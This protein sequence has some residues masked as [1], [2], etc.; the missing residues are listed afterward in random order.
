MG[1]AMLIICAG[2]LISMGFV[3]ISTSN[4]GKMLTQQ[5]VSYAEYTMA[6]NAAHTAIQIAMQ[7]INKDT[8][9]AKKHDYAK[10]WKTTVQ[11]LPIELHIDL[12]ESP[13]YWEPDELRFYSRAKYKN[14][15]VLVESLYLKQPFSSLV[16]DFKSALTFAA[17]PEK[18]SFSIGGNTSINGNAS[19]CEGS[20]PG[21]TYLP[22]GSE[23]FLDDEKKDAFGNSRVEGD[24]VGFEPDENLSYQ[25]T[26]IMIERLYDT[27]G[28]PG[29]AQRLSTAGRGPYTGETF[30]TAKEPGVFIVEDEFRVTG[31]K[32]TGYGILIV[33]TNADMGYIDEDGNLAEAA[34]GA[35]FEFNGLV[36]FENAAEFGSHGTPTINGSVLIGLTD[37]YP[38]GKK[39]DFK[40]N[41][42]GS[43]NYDC[44]GENYAKMAAANA[45]QQ[46]KYTRLV[47]TENLRRN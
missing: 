31:G 41:G 37:A 36:V 15:H 27:L 30:G 10:P 32:S 42:T 17:D 44:L 33:R 5:N 11:G 2:V 13:D 16:P 45:I 3:V 20:K 22:D 43:I 9:W 39:F 29:G 19:H 4:T 35:N 38:T 24:P 6:K 40:M 25:P 21:I 14:S 8:S 26:D 46:L 7:K 1:R 12:D 18:Y 34:F 28:R 23:N 47:S